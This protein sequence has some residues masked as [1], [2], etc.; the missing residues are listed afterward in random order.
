LTRAQ[1]HMRQARAW[2]RLLTHQECGIKLS[3]AQWNLLTERDRRNLRAVTTETSSQPCVNFTCFDR[4]S[5][6]G[7]R[8][9]SSISNTEPKW[10]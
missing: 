9:S 1:Q 6:G 7:P 10:R 5:K 3:L 8:T 4:S 2:R